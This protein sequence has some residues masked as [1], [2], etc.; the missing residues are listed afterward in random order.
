[1]RKSEGV[2]IKGNERF[3]SIEKNMIEEGYTQKGKVQI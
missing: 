2:N 1:M 3:V